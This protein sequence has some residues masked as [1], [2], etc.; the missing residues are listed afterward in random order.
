MLFIC[1]TGKPINGLMSK[2]VLASDI[3]EKYAKIMPKK[4]SLVLPKTENNCR[5][6]PRKIKEV[7]ANTFRFDNQKRGE[8]KF[9]QSSELEKYKKIGIES[10]NY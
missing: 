10:I 7:V 2:V 4:N 5:K 6:T 1:S 3:V 9:H 8:R